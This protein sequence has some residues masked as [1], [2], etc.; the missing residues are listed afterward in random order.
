MTA[1]DPADCKPTSFEHP[2][3]LEGFERVGRTSWVVAA[4]GWK[5]WRYPQLVAAN[6]KHEYRPHW[7]VRHNSRCPPCDRVDIHRK[8]VKARTICLGFCAEQ[9][10]DPSKNRQHSRS[11]Q[12]T[13]ASLCAVPVDNA[14]SIF[15]NNHTH[16]W[17]K[18]QGSRCPSIETL[19]L[20]PLPCTPYR[21]KLG[22]FRQPGA[23]R[24]AE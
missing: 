7:L 14:S 2:I 6:Q 12:L 17:M 11:G 9:D 13:Q 3:A 24:K 18:Q 19:G 4:A 8:L 23:A 1:K 16:S 20:H 10:V 21:F 15:R 22:L 5:Q